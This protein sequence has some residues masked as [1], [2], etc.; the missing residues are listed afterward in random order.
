MS[1]KTDVQVIVLMLMPFM[2]VILFS[3]KFT[4]AHLSVCLSVYECQYQMHFSNS[5]KLF[6][7]AIWFDIHLCVHCLLYRMRIHNSQCIVYI[8]WFYVIVYA[9]K[10]RYFATDS[11]FIVP[12]RSIN[13]NWNWKWSIH[14]IK[15]MTVD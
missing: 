7:T 10:Q 14:K 2:S 11:V 6:T 3:M 5:H 13:W 15:I 4:W 12:S 1:C 9:C 8:K